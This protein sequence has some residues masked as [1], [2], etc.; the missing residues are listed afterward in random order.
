MYSVTNVLKDKCTDN[1]LLVA[2]GVQAEVE[3]P[4]YKCIS[5]LMSDQS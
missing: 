1:D 5:V 3:P 2:G 4:L